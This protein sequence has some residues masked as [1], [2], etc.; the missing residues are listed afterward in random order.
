MT[1]TADVDDWDEAPADEPGLGAV[2][3]V[4]VDGDGD[5]DG[6]SE[7]ETREYSA[8]G[9][10]PGD[11]EAAGDRPLGQDAFFG[12][13]PDA[14]GSSVALFEGDEGTLERAQRV[15]LVKVLRQTLIDGNDPADAKAWRAIERDPAI[16]RSR[17]NDLLLELV[18][19]SARQIA[20]KRQAEPEG[21]ERFPTLLHS[22]AWKR[23]ETI[24]LVLLRQALVVGQRAGQEV[25]H[26]S[27]DEMLD[28]VA[29]FRA[30]S[31]NNHVAARKAASNAFE[32]IITSGLLR[33]S[34]DPDRWRI[35]AALEILLPLNRLKE[36]MAWLQSQVDPARTVY[37]ALGANG[38]QGPDPQ[39]EDPPGAGR[40]EAH[41][42]DERS[43]DEQ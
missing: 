16:F 4:D 31:D 33:K 36:L 43:E 37:P 8:W 14:A 42:G 35:V 6:D 39:D 21:G 15:A 7:D 17:L 13:D 19:D 32:A 38:Q 5:G 40:A 2:D 41:E 25:V 23:E 24:L 12:E 3:D 9:P 22:T 27:R 26:V 10:G 18:V 28:D 29:A 30:A 11:D 34:P 1:A 20:Y